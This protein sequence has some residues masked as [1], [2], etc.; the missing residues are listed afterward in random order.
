MNDMDDEGPT[1]R[2]KL[3]ESAFHTEMCE[4]PV[5]EEVVL[6]DLAWNSTNKICDD[7]GHVSQPNFK[8]SVFLNTNPSRGKMNTLEDCNNSSSQR[9]R[10]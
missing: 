10:L 8:H 3:M 2:D 9:N 4:V 7:E 6:D 1:D 5:D